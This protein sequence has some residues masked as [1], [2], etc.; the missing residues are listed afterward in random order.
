MI[1]KEKNAVLLYGFM[2]TYKNTAKSL[3]ENIIIPNNAS[4][5]ICTY[6]NEGVSNL[7]QDKD[8]N[9]TKAK[10]AKQQDLQGNVVTKSS[11]KEIYGDYLKDSYIKEYN[12][13]KFVQDSKNIFSP[14]F[15]IERFFSLYCNISDVVKLLIDWEEKNNIKFDNLIVTRPDLCF[16][17]KLDLSRMDMDFLNIANNGGNVNPTSHSELY[18][19][20]YYKNV[21]RHEYIPF[22]TIPFS[23]QLII[24]RR[25]NLIKL[26]NLYDKLHDYD[27]IGIP[28]CHPETVL[29]YH[30]GLSQNLNVK[31]N[32]LYYEILRSDFIKIDNEITHVFQKQNHVQLTVNNKYKEKIIRDLRDIK[33][34]TKATIRLIPNI[35]KYFIKE[36]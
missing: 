9:Q 13:D 26:S 1:K 32:Q 21:E 3:L 19:A 12:I 15:P 14:I 11:L 2:R 25:K 23:D 7:S 30:L 18:Y 20:C 31:I 24:S 35:I 17:S 6:S 33:A 29:Y 10:H 4:L 36:I 8:I 5:F 28:L 16:Y 34:G 27:E 22:H